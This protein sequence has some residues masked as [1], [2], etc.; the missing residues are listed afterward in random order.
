MPHTPERYSSGQVSQ[1]P[2]ALIV[3]DEDAVRS[4][5]TRYLTRR[6]WD[7]TDAADGAAATELLAPNAKMAFD[8]VICDLRMPKFS[9][10]AL[11]E[12]LTHARPELLQRLVFSTGDTECVETAK[13]LAEVRR[14]VLGKPFELPELDRIIEAVQSRA[15]AA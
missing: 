14:P 5:M 3:D 12:W 2:R 4:A 7:V 11:Y 6:G 8:L 9:G 1:R 15:R 10:F 13:F